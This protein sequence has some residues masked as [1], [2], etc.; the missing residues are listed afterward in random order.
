MRHETWRGLKN[1]YNISTSWHSLLI[2][3]NLTKL[4][5]QAARKRKNT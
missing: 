5:K 4:D 3:L 1:V 2:Y